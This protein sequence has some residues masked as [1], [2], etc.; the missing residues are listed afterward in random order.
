MAV[1]PP[2]EWASHDRIGRRSVRD[3]NLSS[4][5]TAILTRGPVS[6]RDIARFTDLS[7]GAV[8][9]LVKP[10]LTH[11]Y[12]VEQDG[13]SD[14]PGRPTIPLAVQPDRHFAVGI[15]I[16]RD[17][18]IGVVVDLHAEIRTSTRRPLPAST[19]EAVVASAADMVTELL[20]GSGAVDGNAGV[21]ERTLG[22]G[23]GLAGHV[24]GRSG[25][26]HH[27]PI[28]GWREVP[29]ARMLSTAT[30]LPVLIENDVNTLAVAEQWFGAGREADSFAVVTVGAGIG[31]GMVLR[32]RLWHGASGIAGEL[33][34][35]MAMPD[36][37]GCH[38]GRRGC[39][40]AMASDDAILGAIRTGGGPRVRD[41]AHAAE[42]A[43]AGDTFIREVFTRAGIALGRGL[44]VLLNLVNPP[45][46]ILSGE[47]VHASDLFIDALR[48]EL[49]R[50][51]FSSAAG[52][53]RLLVRPLPD[54]TWARGA[55]ATALRRGVL[56]SVSGLP[57]EVTA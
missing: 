50:D 44:A 14:G 42:L 16:T 43:H 26:L 10:M 25:V 49:R 46:L 56:R 39:L 28:L 4:V 40:E 6:R 3:E 53:C 41:V 34:H 31:A 52:D 55:A 20:D 23:V 7:Q 21:R 11:G 51:A 13:H 38:C 57:H 47:G 36:G 18:L 19:P 22:V 17:E 35:I 15:K 1:R 8:T 45:L 37:P 9:K 5:F 30:G 54:E 12:V 29:L 33:G 48:E 32:G 24:D 2:Y 27:S